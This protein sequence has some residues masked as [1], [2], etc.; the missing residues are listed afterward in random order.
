M[1]AQVGIPQ[2]RDLVNSTKLAPLKDSINVIALNYSKLV[3]KEAIDRREAESFEQY[4]EQYDHDMMYLYNIC[5]AAQD[6]VNKCNDTLYTINKE[7][8]LH[9]IYFYGDYENNEVE[10]DN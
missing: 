10:G 1:S 9:H 4:T 5:R 8:M 7:A 6:L 3:S 2:Y